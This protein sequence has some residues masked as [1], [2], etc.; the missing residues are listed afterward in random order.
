MKK[1]FYLLLASVFAFAF[2]SCSDDDDNNSNSVPSVAAAIV[3]DYESVMAFSLKEMP[4]DPSNSR[5]SVNIA[6][7]GGNKVNITL[8]SVDGGMMVIP[9]ITLTD[10]EVVAE[11][12][13]Y[14]FSKE[15]S[16]TVGAD[17]AQKKYT[18]KFN[19]RINADRTFEFK[20]EMKYG[21]MPF[22]LVLNYIPFTAAD[23][24]AG[25][26]ATD[27]N[28]SMLEMPESGVVLSNKPTLKI[29]AISKDQVNIVLPDMAYAEMNMTIPSITVEK[30]NV[31]EQADKSF[32]IT[33]DYKGQVGEKSVEVQFDG[34]LN[35]DGTF[36]HTATVK[37]GKMPLHLVAVF[38]PQNAEK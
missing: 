17:G 9:A 19:G 14:T 4:G 10:V 34:V 6:A 2:T 16:G 3:G 38:T 33:A 5:V 18:A 25:N 35:A 24:V 22:T 12:G 30:A 28:V 31:V 37:Y 21:T 32:K 26:I 27:M 36:K 7:A 23:M 20:E 8:P 13:G 11:N 1:F 15:V 29:S